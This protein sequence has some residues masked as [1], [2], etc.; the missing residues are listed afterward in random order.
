MEV[1]ASSTSCFGVLDP[2]HGMIYL[3]AILKRFIDHRF[4]QRLR[5]IKQLGMC[6][7]VFPGAM[8]TRFMHSIGTAHLTHVMVLSIRERQPELD[9]SDR[10][11]LCLTIAALLHDLGHPCYSH[12][13]EHF[14]HRIAHTKTGLS[15]EQRHRLRSR[16]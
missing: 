16:S 3:P 11:T 4:F 2:V 1:S 15:D 6:S 13:F 8:H 12:M 7:H 10:D 14:I 9:I 5:L